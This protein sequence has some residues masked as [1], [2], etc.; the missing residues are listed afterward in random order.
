MDP[1]TSR[2]YCGAL[3]VLMLV[4]QSTMKLDV[5]DRTTKEFEE[6]EEY[7]IVAG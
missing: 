7:D 5:L 4:G 3:D 6:L 1:L 2:A